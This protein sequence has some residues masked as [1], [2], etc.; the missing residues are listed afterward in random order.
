MIFEITL[1][2]LAGVVF[3]GQVSHWFNPWILICTYWG[4]LTVK[5]IYNLW[6]EKS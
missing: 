1:M 3:I 2:I 4:V 5:Y 6:K